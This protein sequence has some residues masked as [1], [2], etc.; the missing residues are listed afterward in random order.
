MSTLPYLMLVG[1]ESAPR[2]AVLPLLPALLGVAASPLIS[3]AEPTFGADRAAFQRK[4]HC[5]NEE[6]IEYLASAS[7]FRNSIMATAAHER[8]RCQRLVRQ[9][10][11][12]PGGPC[13]AAKSLNES[14]LLWVIVHYSRAPCRLQ[15]MRNNL[16]DIGLPYEAPELLVA[17]GFDYQDLTPTLLNTC[18]SADFCGGRGSPDQRGTNQKGVLM[19]TSSILHHYL[20]WTLAA[21]TSARATVILEDDL[22]LPGRLKPFLAEALREMPSDWDVLNFGCDQC[23]RGSGRAPFNTHS[24][25]FCSRGQ[26]VSKSGAAKLW[27]HNPFINRAID[28]MVLYATDRPIDTVSLA[29]SIGVVEL[30]G[31]RTGHGRLAKGATSFC[32]SAALAANGT[33]AP[34]IRHRHLSPHLRPRPRR[35]GRGRR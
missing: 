12:Q 20:A 31:T 11:M 21:E 27:R 14:S 32:P 30:S 33:T 8:S 6:Q 5:G 15:M 4:L 13:A 9:H 7:N 35:L 1:L 16:R 22:Q 26:L 23:G 10:C 34:S 2:A 19:V 24:A 3:S 28:S 25:C 29:R 17:T 18:A